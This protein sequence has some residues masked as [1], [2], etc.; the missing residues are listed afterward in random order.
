[1]TLVVTTP[2]N[3][4]PMAPRLI[5]IF[6]IVMRLIVM[7]RIHVVPLP[8]RALQLALVIVARASCKPGRPLCVIIS[9][10]LGLLS[11]KPRQG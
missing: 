4:L 1:M 11:N 2:V 10:A 7:F 6:C 3:M 5:N 8:I 9:L